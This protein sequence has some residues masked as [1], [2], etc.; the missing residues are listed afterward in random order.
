M[1][2]T[3]RFC[4]IALAAMMAVT[5]FAGC[6]G[7]DTSGD[8]GT[9]GGTTGGDTTTASTA[10]GGDT[11]ATSDSGAAASTGEATAAIDWSVDPLGGEGA[12]SPSIKVWGPDA[13]QDILKEQTAA[14]AKLVKDN[15]YGDV[16]IEVIPQGEDQAAT[17]ALQDAEASAD[18]FGFACDQ[19]N[20]LVGA[21]VLVEAGGP[22]A[23]FVKS[24]NS[25]DSVAAATLDG[26][27][28][29]YP[30][31]G[32]NS[33]VL[34][35]NKKYVSDEQAKTL[36]GTLEA[37]KA[38]GKKFSMDAGNGYYSCLFM[39]TGG[40]KIDGL[41]DDGLTQKFT[42]YDEDTLVKTMLAFQKLLAEDYQDIFLNGDEGKVVDGFKSDTVA[43][44][45]GGSW[46]F[47]SVKD[48]LG[49]DAGFAILPTINVD[50]TDTQIINM[51]GYKFIGVN[52]HSKFPAT[53]IALAKYLTSEEC[54][55]QRAE[56][57]NWGPSNKK[58]AESDIVKKDPALAAIL[59]QG[60]NS[61][62]QVS[63][64][65]TFWSP[66]GTFGNKIVDPK[67]QLDEAACKELI[68]QTIAN[69]RDE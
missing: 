61:V 22:N 52:S 60:K 14:F 49:K 4:A 3:K 59:E 18:V 45:I 24:N 44:G 51:F 50:G 1:N 26:K 30:E 2:K 19:L 66:A 39:F 15:G 20:K 67:N 55:M 43:A 38:A 7:G 69:I 37:C 36:E 53:S 58:V 32:D 29:A 47:K 35:Y 8:T 27:I 13:A 48:A 68:K 62:P 28:M 25:E 33:Y 42:E 16:T 54:Q 56:Q 41:E 11:T 34:V 31:T 17:Q 63:L 12:N 65:D 40:L 57:I 21:G 9:T 23:E 64:A 46:N 10:D 6:G 5:A